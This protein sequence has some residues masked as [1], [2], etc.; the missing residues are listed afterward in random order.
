MM[1][2][3]E[4]RNSSASTV[5]CSQFKKKDRHSR[6]DSGVHT[7]KIVD[8]IASVYAG[9]I[10]PKPTCANVLTPASAINGHR[11]PCWSPVSRC[12]NGG[13]VS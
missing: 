8:K 6:L 12:N 7:E 13:A 1:G 11:G 10:L 5:F 2:L 4:L 9:S 3:I